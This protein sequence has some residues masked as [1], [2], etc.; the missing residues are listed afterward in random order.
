MSG[1]EEPAHGRIVGIFEQRL[2]LAEELLHEKHLFLPEVQAHTA[3]RVSLD[4]PPEEHLV[5]L[6][7][8]P[9][10]VRV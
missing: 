1:R 8:R 7:R 2:E 5:L 6:H 10:A 4:L 9:E 3:G